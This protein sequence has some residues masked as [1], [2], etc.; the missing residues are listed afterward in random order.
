MP[1]N[2]PDASSSPAPSPPTVSISG[3][4]NRKRIQ[5]VTKLTDAYLLAYVTEPDG[6]AYTDSAAI[7]AT[8]VLNFSSP[9]TLGTYSDISSD[10]GVSITVDDAKGWVGSQDPLWNPAI[11]GEEGYTVAVKIPSTKF[12]A[13]GLYT[14]RLEV[15]SSSAGT[16]HQVWD[17]RV[18]G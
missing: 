17:L 11:D 3:G 16:F 7:S 10:S 18:N 12:T 9:S 8:H 2:L 13:I 1:L 15:T 14:V 4:V 5:N 6:T